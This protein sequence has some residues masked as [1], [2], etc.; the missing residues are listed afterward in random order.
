MGY[1]CPRK[2]SQMSQNLNFSWGRMLPDHFLHLATI[3]FLSFMTLHKICL[4]PVLSVLKCLY[5]MEN[6]DGGKPQSVELKLC[7]N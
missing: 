3:G 1:N 6:G 5:R 2:P 4:L 7:L